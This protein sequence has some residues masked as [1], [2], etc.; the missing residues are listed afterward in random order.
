MTVSEQ[1]DFKNYY[2]ERLYMSANVETGVLTN[3]SGRRMLALTND[4]LLDYIALFLRSAAIES[5][6]FFI[7]AAE[8]GDATLVKDW[9]TPG[10]SFTNA[11]SKNFLWHSFRVCSFR[12]LPATAGV[13]D[14]RL[15]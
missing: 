15:Q 4:F 7:V 10:V 5:A 12:N 11:A 2:V 8:N 9:P 1:L 6:K 13:I 3:R 14:C